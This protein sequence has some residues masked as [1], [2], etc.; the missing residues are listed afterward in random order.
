MIK[1]ET[2]QANSAADG[3]PLDVLLLLS[4]S[5]A[6][7]EGSFYWDAPRDCSIGS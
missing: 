6:G 4:C 2:P 1:L 3:G 7:A 5:D